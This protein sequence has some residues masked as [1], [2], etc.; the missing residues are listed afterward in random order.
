MHPA[1]PRVAPPDGATLA[2][3][4]P[5]AWRAALERAHGLVDRCARALE[6]TDPGAIDLAPAAR[7]LEAAFGHLYDAFDAR[8]DRLHAAQAAQAEVDRAADELEALD[9][10]GDVGDE[11]AAAAGMLRAARVMLSPAIDAF[12]RAPSAVTAGAA[13]FAASNDAPRLHEVAR[14]SLTPRLDVAAPATAREAPPAPPLPAPGTSEEL[15]G[16]IHELKRRAAERREAAAARRAGRGVRRAEPPPAPTEAA[17]GFAEDVPEAV[18]EDD[19]VAARMRECLEEVA[20]VGT[21]RAPLAGDAWRSSRVLDRR[22][23]AAVDAIAALGP[24]AVGRVERLVRDAPAK[25]PS[26]GFAAAMV[27]GSVAGRDSLAAAL[28]IARHLGVGDAEVRRLVTSALLLAPHGDLALALRTELDDEDPAV[29]ALAIEVLA[30]RGLASTDELLAAARDEAP[31]VCAIAL[32]AL[33]LE[34][35][36]A[37]EE[38][39]EGALAR[40]EAE[41][42]EAAWA[43]MALAGHPRAA[44]VCARELGAPREARAAIH[45][46][47]V[48][49]AEDAARLHAR[50]QRAPSPAL[51]AAVGWAGAPEHVPTLIGLLRLRDE[52]IVLAAATAL[53]R[54]TGARLLETVDVP[55]ESIA[56]EDPPEPEVG[57]PPRLARATSDP[58]DLPAE[59][60]PDTVTRPTTSPDRWSAFW[61]EAAERHRPG[62]RYRRGHPYWPAVSLWELDG[63]P[64]TPAERRLLQRELVIRTGHVVRFDP[65]D[66]VPV[67]EDAL[68]AW[69]PIA[70]RAGAGAGSWA[71]A[72]R[73]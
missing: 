6:A 52:A 41:V 17:P 50:A 60:S 25:D 69:E 53:D 22:M 42:V 16:T 62:L 23:L 43:A 55:P 26:R 7:A 4:A 13:P 47:L 64:V 44:E 34:A 57:E 40:P 8:A 59:G 29:R 63:W 32:P 1:D 31:L 12:V 30:R 72:A 33:A 9:A 35:P 48:G 11:V 37:L 65:H 39:L 28:R 10:D 67:Q 70:R 38:V 14:T 51:V 66:L 73:R 61:S 2:R 27:L 58:R 56:V 5:P 3:Q 49:D 68:R 15:E 71:R 46:A 54:L 21:Q 19:F 45:L 20:M 18:D 24:V 36:R